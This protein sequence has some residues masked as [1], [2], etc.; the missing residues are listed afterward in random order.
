MR[1]AGRFENQNGREG[2]TLPA[3]FISGR[4]RRRYLPRTLS[5]PRCHCANRSAM[6]GAIRS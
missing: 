4:E 1:A 5:S 2:A 3:V 6:C